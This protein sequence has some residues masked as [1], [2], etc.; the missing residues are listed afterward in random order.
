MEPDPEIEWELQQ[1]K[2]SMGLSKDDHSALIPVPKAKR[3]RPIV[4]KLT[5]PLR[6][7]IKLLL[8]VGGVGGVLSG[9]L[10]L[11][12]LPFPFIQEAVD[13]VAPIAL[14]PSYISWDYLLNIR[15]FISSQK[16]RLYSDRNSRPRKNYLLKK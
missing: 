2:S 12:N 4:G 16:A 8:V 6:K 1:L 11:A 7:K 13:G 15:Y 3:T 5:Q 10:W 9:G 14:V